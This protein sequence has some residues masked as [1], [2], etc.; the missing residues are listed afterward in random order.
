MMTL[1]R[2]GGFPM[3][4][5]LIV[6]LVGLTEAALM[7][8]R[9]DRRRLRRLLGYGLALFATTLAGTAAALGAVFH[10]LPAQFADDPKLHLVLLQGLGESMSPGILGF[11]F[12][13]LIALVG[14]VGAGRLPPDPA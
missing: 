8:A 12:I 14:G 10:A 5:I 6:G 13:A 2:E 3:I 11:A 4:F 7:A 9:P 1:M